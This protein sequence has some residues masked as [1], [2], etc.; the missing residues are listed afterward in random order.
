MTYTEIINNT[1]LLELIECLRYENCLQSC[2][3]DS[4][5]N[6]NHYKI[7][8]ILN[9]EYF[10]VGETRTPNEIEAA[11]KNTIFAKLKQYGISKIYKGIMNIRGE[12]T[13]SPMY[14]SI[15]PFMGNLVK[16]ERNNIYGIYNL[17]GDRVCP[18]E[19]DDIYK[20]SEGLFGV[21]KGTK[22]GF[23]NAMGD[24]VIPLSFDQYNPTNDE[25]IYPFQP[26]YFSNGLACLYKETE[27]EQGFGYIDHYGN[28]IFPFIFDFY[29]S[30]TEDVIENTSTKES[31]VSRNCDYYCLYASGSMVLKRTECDEIDDFNYSEY[32][33]SLGSY[34]DHNYDDRLDAYEGDESNMWNTD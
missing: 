18:V 31:D 32:D 26:P 3:I 10:V 15:Q 11:P 20:C 9:K 30:F 5:A 17:S 19:Y 21:R 14:N 6:D 7:Y 29:N 33:C 23:M 4:I 12:Y 28:T 1:D 24:L 2:N 25:S 13:I 22:I 16:V 27:N 34:R 8:A